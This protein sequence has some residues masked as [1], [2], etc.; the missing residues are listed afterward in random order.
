MATRKCPHCKARTSYEENAG[1]AQTRFSNE[2]SRWFIRLD[3]CRDDACEK[4][5]A[6]VTNKV[7]DVT[8]IFPPAG[9]D[10]DELL[11]DGVKKAMLQAFVSLDDK[12]W[13]ACVLMARRA[14]EEAMSDLNAEGRDLY[15]KIDGLS[16]SHR[17]TPDLAAWAH[18]GRLGGKLAAHGKSAEEGKEWNDET[19]AQEIVEFCKWFFRYVY[20]LPTQLAERRARIEPESQAASGET[21]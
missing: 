7:G 15:Q 9:E 17:I 14:L 16:A 6:V 20:I 13:D 8:E 2:P 4:A 3:R 21:D 19:D 12:A 11:P 10:P 18:E 1:S 5:I